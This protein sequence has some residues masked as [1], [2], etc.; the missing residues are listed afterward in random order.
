VNKAIKI[1]EAEF[2]KLISDSVP[3][4]RRD[5]ASLAFHNAVVSAMGLENINAKGQRTVIERIAVGV[6]AQEQPPAKQPKFDHIDDDEDAGPVPSAL[7]W[8]PVDGKEP[9]RKTAQEW[10][11]VAYGPDRDGLRP[12]TPAEW[13]KA[14]QAAARHL[15]EHTPPPARDTEWQPVSELPIEHALRGRHTVMTDPR[16][17]P[18]RKDDMARHMQ[19]KRFKPV[20]AKQETAYLVRLADANRELTAAQLRAKAAVE[21]PG[22]FVG[23]TAVRFEQKLTPIWKKLG[24][25]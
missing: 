12:M 22:M 5:A 9:K 15:L 10:L 21:A 13:R 16:I 25:K 14:V 19:S 11:D 3:A 8:V 1:L 4:H 20:T 7:P 23:M 24:R 17:L 18:A 2:E 6:I